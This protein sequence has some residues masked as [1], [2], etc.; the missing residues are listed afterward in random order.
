[1]QVLVMKRKAL[2]YPQVDSL[3]RVVHS[4]RNTNLRIGIRRSFG[5]EELQNV[6]V[7]FWLP[8]GPVFK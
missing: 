4:G 5:D 7:A 8:R 2:G 3:L 1:M 6:Y